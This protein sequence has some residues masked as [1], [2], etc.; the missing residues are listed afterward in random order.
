MERERELTEFTATPVRFEDFC[1]GPIWKALPLPIKLG[2]L[3]IRRAEQDPSIIN[4]T[5]SP[6]P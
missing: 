2:L 6:S 5:A 1:E 3:H 4:S